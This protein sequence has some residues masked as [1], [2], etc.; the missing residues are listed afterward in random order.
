ML[1]R[2][3]KVKVHKIDMKKSIR[4]STQGVAAD[5]RHS[6]VPLIIRSNG[7][8]INW[9]NHS[10]A[11]LLILGPFFK[12]PAKE[13]RWLPKPLRP[14]ALDIAHRMQNQ[15]RPLTLFQTA[16]NVRHDQI[17]CDFAISFDLA[18]NSRQHLRF[19]YW[20][21]MIDWT[22]EGIAGNTNPRYGRLINI[23]LMQQPLGNN[24]FNRPPQI[25]FFSSHFQ[26]PRKTIYEAAR[27]SLKID[28]FGLAFDKSIRG[29]HNSGLKKYD[30]LQNYRF[31]LC[32]ENGLYPG[33][34]TEKI[35]E[36]FVAGCLP[37]TWA[38]T[39]VCADFNPNAFINL[40]PMT[41]QDFAPLKEILNSPTGLEPF[42][43]QPLLLSAPSI[44]PMKD[45]LREIV[46]QALS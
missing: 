19:P 35:P 20:M 1:A 14:F 41:W 42:T 18:V 8:Q 17:P 46:R 26:E 5:Y 16:E 40:E 33:Y 7:Y 36:A 22:H 13:F 2:A 30:V 6:L 9:V 27:S 4:I 34:Y 23:R 29:H 31:N 11:D 12:I 25:A 10:D 15:N 39:N 28:G 45:Y 38:D 37:L 3:A 43:E 24:L 21:E 44:E 32:P